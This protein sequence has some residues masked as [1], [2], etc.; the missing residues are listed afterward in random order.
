MIDCISYEASM[1]ANQFCVLTTTESSQSSLDLKNIL[2]ILTCIV[3]GSYH[4]LFVRNNDY[5]F[6]VLTR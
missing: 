3:I 5:Q 6:H 2:L 4:I 1:R